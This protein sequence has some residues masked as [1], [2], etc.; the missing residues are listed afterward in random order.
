MRKHWARAWLLFTV[1][2]AMAL[3]A[4]PVAV[5]SNLLKKMEAC[6]WAY[7][8]HLLPKFGTYANFIPSEVKISTAPCAEGPSY[9][10]KTSEKTVVL[11]DRWID[12]ERYLVH[13]FPPH[14]VTPGFLVARYGGYEWHGMLFIDRATGKTTTTAKYGDTCSDPFFMAGGSGALMVCVPD[15]YAVNSVS[16]TYYIGFGTPVQF[17]LLDKSAPGALT[18]VDWRTPEMPRV[19]YLTG[20][21]QRLTK[22]YRLPSK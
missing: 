15:P 22:I 6:K 1:V 2:G 10:F 7:S 21:G 9:I 16:H 3:E 8:D 17:L 11:S 12:G 19:Q 18:S 5:A 14:Q 13:T 20:E 4:A